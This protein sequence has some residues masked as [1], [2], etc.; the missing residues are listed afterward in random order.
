MFLEQARE[1]K[2]KNW[3]YLLGLILIILIS[4]LGSMV[5]DLVVLADSIYNSKPLPKSGNESIGYLSPNVTLLLLIVSY[6][7]FLAGVYFT[8]K[9]VH[10]RSLRS[11]GTGRPK[12][13]W[14]RVW[15]AFGV[16]AAYWILVNM[17][18]WCINP[19]EYIYIFRPLPFLLYF[20]ILLVMALLSSLQE[21]FFFRGYLLQGLGSVSGNRWLPLLVVS[22]LF[23]LM[24]ASHP[25]MVAAGFYPMLLRYLSYALFLGILTLMDD[26]TE[27]AIGFDAANRLVAQSFFSSPDGFFQPDSIFQMTEVGTGDADYALILGQTL[28]IIVLF[29]WI[30]H[31]KYQW[32]GWREKLSGKIPR[33]SQHQSL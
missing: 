3:K 11:V 16:S 23:A 27:L 15:F 5:H 12:I 8:A 4:S 19:E 13:D 14:S 10:R 18:L 26:G 24:Y 33:L 7:I 32:N 21:Q 20:C 25:E 30:C 2:N 6:G 17:L 29:L 1:P 9:F 28:L 31:K 22:V